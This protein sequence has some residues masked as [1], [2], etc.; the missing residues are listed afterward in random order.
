MY[1][2]GFPFMFTVPFKSLR[3]G[4]DVNKCFVI[5]DFQLL[6]VSIY[7]E[8]LLLLLL[9]ALADVLNFDVN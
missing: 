3:L 2:Q 1:D 6:G 9:P 8:G 5:I 7:I 4:V